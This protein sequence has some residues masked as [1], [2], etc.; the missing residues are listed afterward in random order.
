MTITTIDRILAAY[1][2]S[3]HLGSIPAAKRVQAVA[4]ALGISEELVREA[5]EAQREVA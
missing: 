4:Q 5:L 2:R 3:G 1:E